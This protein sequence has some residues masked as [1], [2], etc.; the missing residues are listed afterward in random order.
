M[1]NE[2]ETQIRLAMPADAPQI[3][4]I[5]LDSLKL[6]GCYKSIPSSSDA[7]AAFH[8]RIQEPQGRSCI[9][10]GVNN[11]KVVGWQGL[12]DLGVTQ[13]TQAAMSSTYVAPQSHG[14]GIGKHLLSYATEQAAHRGFDYVVGYIRTDNLAPINIVLSLGWKFVGVLPR[15]QDDDTELA[16]YAYAVPK[17]QE[18]ARVNKRRACSASCGDC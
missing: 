18:S 9:W 11:D 4:R 5:W 13:I 17:R 15:D 3:A 12:S 1:T 8:Q 6:S 14:K 2:H 10:V 7:V 16:Y